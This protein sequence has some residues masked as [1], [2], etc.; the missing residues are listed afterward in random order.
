M[1]IIRSVYIGLLA[2]FA[3]VSIEQAMEK[4]RN[5]PSGN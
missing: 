2:T 4:L 1:S 3:T 5:P